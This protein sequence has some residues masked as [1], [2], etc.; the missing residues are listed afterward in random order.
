MEIPRVLFDGLSQVVYLVVDVDIV[1]RAVFQRD[2]EAFPEGH[3]PIAVEAGARVHAHRQRA[4]RRVFVQS[5][6]EEIPE[7]AF[8]S[9]YFR[10]VPIEAE[11][12]AAPYPCGGEPDLPYLSHIPHIRHHKRLA[13]P[14]GHQR[15]HLPS[16]PQVPCRSR[17]GPLFYGRSAA[18]SLFPGQILRRYRYCL[19]FTQKSKILHHARH[20]SF[21]FIPLGILIYYTKGRLFLSISL[22]RQTILWYNIY[23]KRLSFPAYDHK[24]LKY[25]TER[26]GGVRYDLDHD[27]HHE[28]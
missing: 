10:T 15:V 4:D 8:D 12:L 19:P 9:R 14:D 22:L 28:P 5:V 26:S 1:L 2:A 21:P 24:T 25:P 11:Y 18:L 3:R 23:V 13:C 17:R 6:G 20:P 16:G 7:G 27:I